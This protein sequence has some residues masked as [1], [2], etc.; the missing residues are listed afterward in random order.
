MSNIHGSVGA[1]VG[2]TVGFGGE[3]IFERLG[4]LHCRTSRIEALLGLPPFSCIQRNTKTLQFLAVD[5]CWRECP[6]ITLEIS[7][8]CPCMFIARLPPMKFPAGND[9]HSWW[10]LHLLKYECSGS[11]SQSSDCFGGNQ[12]HVSENPDVSKWTVRQWQPE[13]DEGERSDW[14]SFGA[15]LNICETCQESCGQRAILSW[16]LGVH[17]R[18]FLSKCRLNW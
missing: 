16:F 15:L 14:N 2:A 1:T 18:N 9:D 17:R 6:V 3:A 8:K 12:T 4:I 13:E 5:N 11:S 10:V 7:W